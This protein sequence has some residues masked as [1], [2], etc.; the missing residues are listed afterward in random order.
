MCSLCKYCNSDIICDLEI[1]ISAI[2]YEMLFDLTHNLCYIVGESWMSPHLHLPTSI[3][4]QPVAQ[5]SVNST[6]AILMGSSE[7]S[8]GYTYFEGALLSSLKFNRFNS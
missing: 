5:P 7:V 4:L 6:Y 8:P 2:P 3:N 1:V